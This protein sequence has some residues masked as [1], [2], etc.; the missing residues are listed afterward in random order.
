MQRARREPRLVGLVLAAAVDQRRRLW[1]VVHR[2]VHL[3]ALV[4]VLPD[5]GVEAALD[6]VRPQRLESGFGAWV[7]AEGRSAGG[8]PGVVNVKKSRSW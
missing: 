8:T 3:P 2:P 5:L 4:M 1:R 6:A 7:G